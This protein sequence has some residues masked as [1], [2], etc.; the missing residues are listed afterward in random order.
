MQTFAVENWRY[1]LGFFV[2][3]QNVTNRAN[4]IGYSG[5]LIS[6]FFGRATSVTSP[7]KVDIGINLTF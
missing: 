5:V 4:Y 1:R 7:R 3:V 6:P 2:N